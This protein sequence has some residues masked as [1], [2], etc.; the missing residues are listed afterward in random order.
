M[1]F[2]DS[3]A[4]QEIATRAEWIE[5]MELAMLKSITGEIVLPKRMHL[6]HGDDTFLIM[7]CITDEY[8]HQACFV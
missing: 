3:I 6:D 1:K 5:A 2:F 4:I 8:W 7:P